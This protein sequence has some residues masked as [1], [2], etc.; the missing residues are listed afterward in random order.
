VYA[1]QFLKNFVVDWVEEFE[2]QKSHYE[3]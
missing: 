3:L 1:Q 2:E